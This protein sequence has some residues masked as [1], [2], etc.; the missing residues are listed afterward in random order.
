MATELN[1]VP[2]G[3]AGTGLAYLLGPN[4]ALQSWMGNVNQ[5][6]KEEMQAAKFNAQNQQR[7]QQLF[8]QNRIQPH[9]GRLYNKE[10]NELIAGH[11]DEGAKAMASGVNPYNANYNDPKQAEFAERYMRDRG[12][13][14]SLIS[15]VQD[16]EK[17][18][19][20]AVKRYNEKPD[21]FDIDDFNKIVNFGNDVTIDQ[22]VSGE[23]DLPTLGRSFNMARDVVSQIP[24]MPKYI[25][26][27]QVNPD[28][29]RSTVK[30]TDAN[31]PAITEAVKTHFKYGPGANQL[32]KRLRE[33]G[34]DNARAEGILGTTDEAEIRELLDTEFRSPTDNNPVVVLMANSRIPAI[35]SPEYEKFLNESVRNQLKAERVAD[36]LYND[37][38]KMA[39][40][41]V[42]P[43]YSNM[44][45]FMFE[46]ERRRQKA[47]ARADRREAS[48]IAGGT[49][50]VSPQDF[51]VTEG[52]YYTNPTYD[53][54]GNPS[55]GRQLAAHFPKQVIVN[56]N[57]SF[58]LPQTQGIYHLQSGKNKQMNPQS[59]LKVAG[60]GYTKKKGGN[61]DKQVMVVDS[62]GQQ[63]FMDEGKL[64]VDIRNSDQYRMANQVLGG[65][66]ASNT[67]QQQSQSSKSATRSQIK[68]LVGQPGY[69]GYSEQELIDYYKSQGY[70]IK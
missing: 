26:E 32:T 18:Q 47:D 3:Q 2:L 56:A 62:D 1:T 4:T 63:Y 25:E 58:T 12:N 22:L 33:A 28:G 31:I 60:I 10:I 17:R 37:A 19:Q 23:A 66:P 46:Q 13:I 42:N 52:N 40:A 43:K 27:I 9:T 59:V 21:D 6:R 45:N 65:P 14:T 49:N 57:R 69:E 41:K 29:T 44:P 36:S 64:P 51:E 35:G 39:S 8:N 67:P 30:A 5:R 15:R 50:K 61:Y 53:E 34:F 68:S 16:I 24:A 70:D 48:Q 38:I 11:L 55:G 7:G 54:A 20:D